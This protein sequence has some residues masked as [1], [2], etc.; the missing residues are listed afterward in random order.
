MLIAM[1]GMPASGKSVL[2]VQ[3]AA[4]LPAI[5]LDKDK[6][7]A[8]LFPPAE[9]EY[10][11]KQDDFCFDILLQV[12]DYLLQKGRDV[13]LDGRPFAHRYQMDHV[14]DF[15]RQKQAPIKVI[16]CT[17]SDESFQR[18]LEQDV[19]EGRHLAANRSF[20]MFLAMRAKADPLVVPSL[21]VDTDRPLA[22]CL[23][24]SLAYIKNSPQ[25]AV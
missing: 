10:S 22:E 5:I 24:E 12:A 13:I 9:I 20:E 19:S 15:A 7:R 11:L 25:F 4:A 8:A 23:A 17:C 21:V 2:A 1:T 18:R 6:M 3:I 16:E 14:V